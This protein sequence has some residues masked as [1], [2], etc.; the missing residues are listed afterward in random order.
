MDLNILKAGSIIPSV[1]LALIPVTAHA[2]PVEDTQL[3]TVL[4]VSGPI[5]GNIVFAADG[6]F[7]IVDGV[8]RRGQTLI[9]GSIG[10]KVRPNLTLSAGYVYSEIDRVG[11]PNSKENRAFQQVSWTI[12]PALGGTLS[13]RTRLEERWFVGFP[14]TGWRLRQQLRLLAPLSKTG[15]SLILQSEL[16]IHLN[17]IAAGPR[18]GFDQLRTLVGLSLPVT[19]KVV[20]EVGYQPIYI[21]GATTDRLNHT[22]PVTLVIKL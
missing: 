4:N 13:S 10:V 17:S 9:R 5:K 6:R 19:K 8:S 18:A 15:A 1:A 14:D 20:I 2:R 7:Q 21:K 12:G 3:W 22:I 11:A 16:F